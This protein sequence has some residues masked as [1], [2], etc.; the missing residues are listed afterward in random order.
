ML[1]MARDIYSDDPSTVKAIMRAVYLL[2]PLAALSQHV[3]TCVASGRWGFLVAGVV[4]F[5][6]AVL[7]GIGTWVAAW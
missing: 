5:P 1:G 2:G 4:F 3:L 7:H 6:V